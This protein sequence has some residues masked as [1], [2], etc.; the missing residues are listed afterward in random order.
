[1]VSAFRISVQRGDAAPLIVQHDATRA[2][3]AVWVA[4][5][6]AGTDE[7]QRIDAANIILTKSRITGMQV[8]NRGEV[9][10]TVEAVNG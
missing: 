7:F 5:Y 6:T 3:A 4:G 10:V 1:M 2:R 8:L 9:T